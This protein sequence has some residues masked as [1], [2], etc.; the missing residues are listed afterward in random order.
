MKKYFFIG[1]WIMMATITH[2]QTKAV[3]ETGDEV[4]LY[5]DGTWKYSNDSIL[6]KKTIQLNEAVFKKNTTS[7]FL[8]KSTRVNV[9][10]WINPKDWSFE[11]SKD[12][13]ASEFQFQRKDEDLYGMLIAEKVEI[14]IENLKE[15][16]LENAKAAAPDIKL[17]KEEYRMVNGV[18][19]FMMQ[20]SGTVQ[21]MKVTYLGYYYSS[22]GGTI[23]LLAYTSQNLFIGYFKDIESFLNGFVVL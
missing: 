22:A 8:V 9:G 11:K 2:A 1:T 14:P 12:D 17:V 7:T 23:Q 10:I 21:G 3:T 18:K 20:M 5:N 19:I 16:A 4:I 13:E 15:I 6:E